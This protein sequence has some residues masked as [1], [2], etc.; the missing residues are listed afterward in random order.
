[1][2]Q[3]LILIALF[4]VGCSH[5]KQLVKKY[6]T[7]EDYFNYIADNW[8]RKDN[9]FFT[10]KE[11]KDTTLNEW[12]QLEAP[13]FFTTQWKRNAN[14]CLSNMNEK[15]IQQLFGK[16]TRIIEFTNGM[17]DKDGKN[18]I[19]YIS[20]GDCEETIPK[21]NQADKCGGVSFT[22]NAARST[23][24]KAKPYM[25]YRGYNFT[26]LQEMNKKEDEK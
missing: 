4:M 6:P 17:K 12:Q 9:G 2:K 1:M 23:S 15:E 21:R 16:P 26:P 10:I 3:L 20:D 5:H 7:C 19:Y 18:F 14:R 22:F 25:A 8:E 24:D 13:P 11:V